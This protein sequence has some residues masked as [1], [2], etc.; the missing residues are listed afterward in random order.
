MISKTA[1][2]A[3]RSVAYL[4]S[5]KGEAAAASTVAE[6]TQTPRRYLHR[7]LQNL[8]SAGLIQSRSGPGGGYSLLKEPSKITIFDVVEAVEPIQR[9]HHCPLGLKSHT[10]LCPLHRELDRVYEQTEQALRSVHIE[11]LIAEAGPIIP[12]CESACGLKA[13]GETL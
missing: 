9:I 4:A 8:V 7:V 3:L 6:K 2:Y 5:I 10:A 12:L 11:E 13:S 1:E